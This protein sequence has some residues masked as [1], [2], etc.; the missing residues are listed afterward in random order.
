MA[1]CNYSDVNL[2]TNITSNDIADVDI[3]SLIAEATKELNRLINVFI[4]REKIDYIDETR[5]NKI[6]GSNTTYYVKNWKG[7]YLADMDND[8]DVDTD[9]II[10]YQVA[11]DGT[12]TKLT[13]SSVDADDCKFIL[14]S[15][16]SS[17]VK[18]YVTYEWCYKDPSVPDP[19]IKLACILITSAYCYGKINIGMAPQTAFGNVKIYRHINSF[20]IYYKRFLEVV[21]KINNQ[22][23]DYKE[24]EVTI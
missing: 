20:D 7:K 19:L 24:S 5:E 3:T 9:D 11:S 18:L 10:V 16:P 23:P 4:V 21:S 2:M 14:N 17:G 13:V 22:M 8:G 15:A 6:D 1:Y 12:E